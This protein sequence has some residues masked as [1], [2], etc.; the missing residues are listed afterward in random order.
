MIRQIQLRGW[1]V[2][3]EAWRTPA[4]GEG[5]LLI[6]FLAGYAVARWLG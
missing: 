1:T 5:W 6:G 3:M 4:R 2:V